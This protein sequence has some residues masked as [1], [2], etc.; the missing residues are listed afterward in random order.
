MSLERLDANTAVMKLA[1]FRAM[2]RKGHLDRARLVVSYLVKFKHGTIAIQTEEPDLSSMPIT[3]Y[4]WEK[5]GLRQS[6]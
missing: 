3:S 5:N 6:Y 2:P 1:S 4:E